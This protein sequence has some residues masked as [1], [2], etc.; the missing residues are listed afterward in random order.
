MYTGR[1]HVNSVR[2]QECYEVALTRDMFTPTQIR[3]GL[4]PSAKKYTPENEIKQLLE[5][6]VRLGIAER[7]F[8]GYTYYLK[9]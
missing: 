1:I 2:A 9:T 5:E 6:W 7:G 4:K 8:N 3:N